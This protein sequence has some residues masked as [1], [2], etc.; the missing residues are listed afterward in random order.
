VLH[1]REQCI[2]Y[3]DLYYENN[4]VIFP[5]QIIKQLNLQNIMTQNVFEKL[6]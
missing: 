4:A 1:R 2:F 3:N 5:M 6:V